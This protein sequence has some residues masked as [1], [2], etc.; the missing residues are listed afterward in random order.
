MTERPLANRWRCAVC[1]QIPAERLE[2]GNNQKCN[3]TNNV[4]MEI[5]L[6]CYFFNAH[7]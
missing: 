7:I 4:D 1:P 6:K 5:K 3:K 2:S